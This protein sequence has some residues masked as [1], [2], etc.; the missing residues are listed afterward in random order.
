MGNLDEVRDPVAGRIEQL[1]H[2]LDV[3]WLFSVEELFSRKQWYQEELS[4]L[5]AGDTSKSGGMLNGAANVRT[6]TKV[7]DGVGYVF[8][9][10]YTNTPRPVTFTWHT[11]PTSVEESQTGQTFP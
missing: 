8:A 9:Y 2:N 7:V 11:A 1:Q 3:E 6:R 4:A 5:Q 10:N